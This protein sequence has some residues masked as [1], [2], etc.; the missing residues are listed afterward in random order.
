LD[1]VV[2]IKSMED[3]N[4]PT[5]VF[6]EKK[7][8]DEVKGRLEGYRD[9]LLNQI[10]DANV[11]ASMRQQFAIQVA[12]F[13]KSGE[14]PSGDWAFGTFHNVPV[15][16]TITMLSKFQNDVRNS[17][18]MILEHLMS[19]VHAEDYKFDALTAIA[20]PKTSYALEGQEIEATIMLA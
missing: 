8:G 17:E 3:I 1:G 10:S 15:I 11:K 9:F 2:Q 5:E 13:K 6:V 7:K 16:G 20:V 12:D 19:Q 14:N 4:T 18:A